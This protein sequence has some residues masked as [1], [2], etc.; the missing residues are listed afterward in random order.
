MIE[1]IINEAKALEA[2]AIRGE[3]DSQKAYEDMVKRTNKAT[4]EANLEV[5]NKSAEKGKAE[6]DKAEAEVEAEAAMSELEML[7][8]Q[9]NDLHSSCD[10]VLKNFDIRQSRRDDEMESLKSAIG[11]L[12]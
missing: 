9:A 12:A 2:E 8:N 10:F 1:E 7:A 3:E 11:I 5:T 4:D 6:G